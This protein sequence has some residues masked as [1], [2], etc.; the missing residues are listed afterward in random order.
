MPVWY[1]AQ[2]AWW[3]PLERDA[4]RRFG[5]A[6]RHTYRRDSLT[7][8]LTGLDVIGE[9]DPIDVNISFYKEPP[10][11]TYGLKPQDFPRVHAKPRAPSKHRYSED[12]ALCL[13]HPLDPE[14]RRW[15]SSKGLLDLIEIVR[16]HLFLEHYWRLT[17]GE[18]GGQWLVEDAPHGMPGSGAWRSSRR[19]RQQVAGG[20]GPR[21][22]R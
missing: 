15:T 19:Q 5:S 12:D 13:W 6:L 7:Y 16:T 22:P 1:G 3:A 17:G 18:H 11:L 2:P 9:P 4:R 20:R 10:Y 21:P 14:E 8:E